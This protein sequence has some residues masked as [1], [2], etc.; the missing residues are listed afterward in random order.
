MLKGS[1]NNWRQRLQIFSCGLLFLA[2]FAPLS[3]VL[4]KI[5]TAVA[6]AGM[7]VFIVT[8]SVSRREAARFGILLAPLALLALLLS[9]NPKWAIF[10]AMGICVGSFLWG[11][12]REEHAEYTAER[13]RVP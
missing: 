12:V 5:L 3:E 6:V 11:V 7:L 9:I 8:D 13:E 10:G 2:A 1:M 4:A